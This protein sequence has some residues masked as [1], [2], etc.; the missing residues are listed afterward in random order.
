MHSFVAIELLTFCKNAKT[1]LL[2]KKDLDIQYIN[3]FDLFAFCIYKK[4]F[5]KKLVY[6]YVCKLQWLPLFYWWQYYY[7]NP[8]YFQFYLSI[9]LLFGLSMTSD[10]VPYRF[11]IF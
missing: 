10:I 11:I 7:P 1:I 4:G 9:S 6:V 8:L 5:A 2:L 3:R